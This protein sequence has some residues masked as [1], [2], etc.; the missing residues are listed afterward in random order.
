MESYKVMRKKGLCVYIYIHKHI[1]YRASFLSLNW[2]LSHRRPHWTVPHGPI[3][4]GWLLM[5][6]FHSRLG[7]QDVSRRVDGGGWKLVRS[8]FW[9]LFQK[10]GI[11]ETISINMYVNISKLSTH[12]FVYVW[13]AKELQ[14]GP[15]WQSKEITP[16]FPMTPGSFDVVKGNRSAWRDGGNLGD[17]RTMRLWGGDL[18]IQIIQVGETWKNLHSSRSA[19]R[20][21]YNFFSKKYTLMAWFFSVFARQSCFVVLMKK[22][23]PRRTRLG[24][25]PG[26]CV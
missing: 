18:S 21:W 10:P 17:G 19:R 8:V 20:R 1:T 14:F 7:S 4:L 12:F 3:T 13:Y 15:C 23:L 16:H 11:D 6:G 26:D 5:S 25:L 2:F 9:D 22:D 24:F